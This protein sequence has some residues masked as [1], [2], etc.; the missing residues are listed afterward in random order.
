MSGLTKQD[1]CESKPLKESIW[2]SFRNFFL[3]VKQ[4]ALLAFLVLKP[5]T[6]QQTSV[7]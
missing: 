5:V 3:F 6:L 7:F 4:I 2:E 1:A